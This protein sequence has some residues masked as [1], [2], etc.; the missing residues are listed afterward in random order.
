MGLGLSFYFYYYLD[1]NDVKKLK[2]FLDYDVYIDIGKG[3]PIST[4]GI[5]VYLVSNIIYNPLYI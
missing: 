4:G 3:F 5:Y 2:Y 1:Y